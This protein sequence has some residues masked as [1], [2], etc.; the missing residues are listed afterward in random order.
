VKR[1]KYAN[2]EAAFMEQFQQ[3]Q[4][5]NLLFVL[6]KMFSSAQKCGKITK[7]GKA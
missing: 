7:Q 4:A 1:A 2:V 3:K 6:G 5:V